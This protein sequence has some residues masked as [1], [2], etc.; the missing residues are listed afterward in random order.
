MS[1]GNSSRARGSNR[2]GT[3]GGYERTE[4]DYYL[5]KIQ[6]LRAEYDAL[7]PEWRQIFLDGLPRLDAALVRDRTREIPE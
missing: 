3:G 4:M 7:A 2:G 5:K 1:M 6:R